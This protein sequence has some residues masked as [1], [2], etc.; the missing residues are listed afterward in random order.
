MSVFIIAEAGVNHDGRLD[1]AIALVDA[2]ASAGADA[3]KFQTF[4]ADALASAS[5]PR[6]AYQDRNTGDGETHLEMLRRLE[7]S[8]DNHHLLQRH[9]RDKGIAFLSTPF[10]LG[11]L[12]FLVEGLGL[13]TIKLG[14]GELTNGPLLRAAARTGGKIIL[15]TGMA[16]LDEVRQALAMLAFAYDREEP[17]TQDGLRHALAG[18]T[19]M[20]ADKVTL[21]HCTTEYPSPFVDVNLRAMATLTQAFGL[22]VGFSDHTDGIAM[23]T[24]AVALGACMIEKHLTLDR[25]L[26][27]PDHKASLEPPDFARMVAAVRQVEV[28]LGDGTKQPAPS[29][30]ANMVVARKSLVAARPIRC[31]ELLTADNLAVMRPGNGASPMTYWDRLGQPA[32]RDYAAGEVLSP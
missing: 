20:L 26:P 25:T 24:A 12:A 30:R 31:G 13:D 5:A 6:A 2:A 3:V 23:A 10:D 18:G 11:S 27:G 19:A 1:R 16:T 28:A 29:E 22:S 9:C 17:P 21:L 8:E 14:S 15:S 32:D 7:L 4:K